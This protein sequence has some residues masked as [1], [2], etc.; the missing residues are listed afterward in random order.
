MSLK[1]CSLL[2]LGHIHE[3]WGRTSSKNN[4][5]F[6]LL[7]VGEYQIGC[8]E[9]LYYKTVTLISDWSSVLTKI[10]EELNI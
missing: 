4:F 5:T 9:G 8:V 10:N 1:Y 3:E 7:S 2:F 6:Q